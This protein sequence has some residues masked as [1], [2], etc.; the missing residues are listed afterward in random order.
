MKKV[1]AVAVLVLSVFLLT[2]CWN[3]EIGVSTEFT[4]RGGAGSRTFIMDVMDDSLST[5]PIINPDDPDGSEAKGAVLNDKYLDGGV[6][7]IQTWL[8]ANAPD[9]MTVE[10]MSTEGYHRYFTLTFSWDDFDEFLEK[11]AA[12]VDLSP[13]MDWSDFEAAELPTWVCEG[14]TCT[15]T[16]TADIVNASLDWAITGV[17]DDIYV[18]GDL[19]GFVTKDSIAVLAN[20]TVT[21]GENSF[22]ELQHYDPEAV[23]GAGT[24]ATV[25]VTS[26][27]FT[28]AGEFP[29][30]LVLILSIVGGVIVIAGGVA[31]FM[32]TKK[33]AA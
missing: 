15:F 12:L 21:M 4:S 31:I 26:Q 7:A 10:A 14:S 17:W 19:A 16:E 2:G 22:S 20:Y 27:S 25:Y 1:L 9:F 3:G 18:E 5:V 33:K 11:Y 28:L 29:S 24:G 23:D 13:S 32:L 6:E 30:S 8:E